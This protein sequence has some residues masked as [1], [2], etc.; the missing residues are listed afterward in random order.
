[1]I[2]TTPVWVSTLLLPGAYRNWQK[3]IKTKH[4]FN[5]V[6]IAFNLNLL[7]NL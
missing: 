7:F 2:D 1:M 3:H 5:Y 6:L 4:K